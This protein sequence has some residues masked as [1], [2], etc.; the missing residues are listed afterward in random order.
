MSLDNRLRNYRVDDE[1]VEVE[2]ALAEVRRRARR[3]LVVRRAGVAALTALAVAAAIIV[4]G[5]ITD[6]RKPGGFVSPPPEPRSTLSFRPAVSKGQARLI[7]YTDRHDLWIYDVRTDRAKRLTAD[8]D[9]KEE[10]NP[11]FFGTDYVLYSTTTP[12]AIEAIP[13]NGGGSQTIVRDQGTILDFDVSPDGSSIV[14]LQ[15]NYNGDAVHRLKRVDLS[16]GKSS[17]VLSLGTP[18]G[19]G[20]GSEDE[21][22]VAWSP[23]GR[24]I[25]VT[26]TAMDD[27][28]SI[29]LLDREGRLMTQP[30]SGTHA[31]WSPDGRT[32]YYRGY[33]GTS[34]GLPPSDL[35]WRAFSVA[36]KTRTTLGFRRGSNN[37]TVSPDGN[38]VSYDTSYFGDTSPEAIRSGEVPIVY[39]YDLRTRKETSLKRGALL[40]L[41]ISSSDVLVTDAIHPPKGRP[42]LNSW[43]ATGTITKITVGG[44][45][46]PTSLTA[47]LW[48]PAVLFDR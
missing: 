4:P 28:R 31:R 33:A 30:W 32:I 27:G 19:R 3:A 39:V 41:W 18:P 40:P 42:T 37:L 25:L 46:Q 5:L 47:T 29:F 24:S 13:V 12:T 8:A 38:R 16:S 17:V 48:E 20:A 15:T 6:R 10:S 45:A 2:S 44:R 1:P 14:Y 26:D 11:R 34:L 21:T 9:R 23:D 35:K 36:T 7:A 22:S 43:E